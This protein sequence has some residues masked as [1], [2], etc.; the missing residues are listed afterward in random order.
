[1][2]KNR[3]GLHKTIS[4]IFDG[5]P[6]E[7]KKNVQQP[8]DTPSPAS[9]A[10]QS[11]PKPPVQTPA[12]PARPKP[13][14]KTTRVVEPPRPQQPPPPEPRTVPREQ[15]RVAPIKH[16]KPS[17]LQQMCEQI[18]GKLFA[19]KPGVDARRQKTMVILVPILFVIFAVVFAKV[20]FPPATGSRPPGPTGG[21][22]DPTSTPGEIAWQIPK[23]YPTTLRDPMKFASVPQNTVVDPGK[24]IVNSI[25]YSKDSSLAL[26]NNQIVRVGDQVNGV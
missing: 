2:A 20:L 23:P 4:S 12:A 26:V 18:K 3:A 19:P 7:K 5:V 17:A 15:P 13:P 9:E 16:A 21:P 11:Q 22:E 6:L 14:A 8:P 24:L 25:T 1:M 10:E